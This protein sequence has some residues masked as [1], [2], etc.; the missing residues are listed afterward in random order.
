MAPQPPAEATALV[1]LMLLH[2][3]RRDAR[4]DG[5]GD[6]VLL[7]DQDRRRWDRQQ[8]AEALPLVEEA[9]R[10]GPGP[11]ALQAA[12]AAQH[13]Q[14]ARAEDTDWPQIV[15]LY[16]LLERLQPSPIVSLNRAV[17]VAMVDGPQ[18]GL[19]LI[20]ALAAT[21]DLDGYHLLHAAR[22]DLLRR[23][24]YTVEAAKSYG[25][26]LALVTN[27]SERRFLERRLREAQ[28]IE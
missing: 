15:R 20:D 23:M 9:F 22:A 3:S 5:H 18:P 17:A 14:A 26:A 16:D 24:G 11:F 6:V 13:C 19:A 1:A 28:T 4:L 21:G 8:I 7:E 27:D 12:I 2:D 25:R 10:G